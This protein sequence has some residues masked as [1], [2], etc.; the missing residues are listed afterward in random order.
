MLKHLHWGLRLLL[1]AVIALPL[2]NMGL[3][4]QFASDPLERISAVTIYAV[5]LWLF[6]A[7]N[8]GLDKFFS[9][10]STA[11][12]MVVATVVVGAAVRQL[13]G[14][15]GSST[16]EMLAINERMINVLFMLMLSLPYAFFV[17]QSF[18]VSTLLE[19]VQSRSKGS[20]IGI[21]IAV[22]MRVFQHIAEMFPPLFSAW[23]EE[24]PSQFLPRNRGDWPQQGVLRRLVNVVDWVWNALWVWA[25]VLFVFSLKA[26]PAINSEALR[27]YR[28]VH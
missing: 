5:L 26:V 15:A 6:I 19:R 2:V 21:Y 13:L 11:T 24:H 20:T 22:W 14:L 28:K 18:S 4:T 16:S 3:V 10:V 23:K 27:C 1:L 8:V 9:Y 7:A 17:V 12:V 25:K